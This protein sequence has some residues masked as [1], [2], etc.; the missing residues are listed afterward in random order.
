[1]RCPPKLVPL[2][3]A[4]KYITQCLHPPKQFR[5]KTRLNVQQ[6]SSLSSHRCS[7]LSRKMCLL[8]KKKKKGARGIKYTLYKKKTQPYTRMH[9]DTKSRINISFL[10]GAFIRIISEHFYHINLQTLPHF[11]PHPCPF[12]SSSASSS[13]PL[14]GVG[15]NAASRICTPPP[16]GHPQSSTR[17]PAD[18]PLTAAGF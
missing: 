16:L 4:L 12:V 13:A 14:Q 11:R 2:K 3:W 1:M 17:S 7:V 9:I 18:L 6:Y 10:D 15:V 8:K 5:D